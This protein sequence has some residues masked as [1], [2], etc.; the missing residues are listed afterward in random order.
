MSGYSTSPFFIAELDGHHIK[1][2]FKMDREKNSLE[3][4]L[5]SVEEKLNKSDFFI[6]YFDNHFNPHP[7]KS[8]A[9]SNE[10][11]VC[12]TLENMANY[13]LNSEEVKEADRKNRPIY[14]FHKSSEKFEKR[15]GRENLTVNN[16]SENVNLVE[17]ENV[18][19]TLEV[20]KTN[21]RLPK[22]QK[23]TKEDLEMNNK[24]GEIL[25][26]YQVFLDLI[27]RKLHEP[28]S[29]Q[30]RYLSNAKNQVKDDMIHVKDM[31][32]GVYGYNSNISESH[33]PDL[34][35]FDFTDFETVKFMLTQPKPDLTFNY[36]MWIIWKDFQDVVEKADLTEYEQFLYKCLSENWKLV[37]ISEALDVDYSKIRRT[38]IPNVVKKIADVGCKYD[39]DYEDI[40]IKLKTKK[41]E[42]KKE[43]EER[44]IKEFA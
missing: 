43:L 12:Q 36:E 24:V 9:L 20:K 5:I 21:S 17:E 26:D 11:N 22:K 8:G 40:A 35:I 15:L 13:I 39:A 18:L 44:K 19:H 31:L 23:I 41:E 37:D 42:N 10:I 33:I 28:Y 27:E 34:D 38:D 4:R 14:S 7:N 16:G 3:D 2:F 32:M 6:D 25:R 1:D 29:S 30:W